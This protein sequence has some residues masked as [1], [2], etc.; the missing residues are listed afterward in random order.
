MDPNDD[1]LVQVCNIFP[2]YDPHVIKSVLHLCDRNINMAI[3][4]IQEAEANESANGTSD[5]AV[6]EETTMQ[7][8]DEKD[9]EQPEQPE[10]PQQETTSAM[11]PASNPSSRHS[12]IH[13]LLK[14]GRRL[15]TPVVREIQVVVEHM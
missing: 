10:Q 4:Y 11:R 5:E 9:S 15:H 7:Y 8:D 3:D 6:V 13:N 1:L 14:N 12:L 2:T